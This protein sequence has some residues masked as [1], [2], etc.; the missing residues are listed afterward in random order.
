MSNPW[1][2]SPEPERLHGPDALMARISAAGIVGR[3]VAAIEQILER[4]GG[5]ATPELAA[6]LSLARASLAAVETPTAALDS[7]CLDDGT[8]VYFDRAKGMYCCAAGHCP[9]A[10]A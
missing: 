4:S 3:Q 8:P 5:E 10:G 6:R 9:P 1:V 7:P 2:G